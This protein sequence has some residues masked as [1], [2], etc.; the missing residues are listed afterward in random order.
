MVILGACLTLRWLLIENDLAARAGVWLVLYA[1]KAVIEVVAGIYAMFYLLVAVNYR[2]TE[3]SIRDSQ[4][5]AF[6]RDDVAVAYLCCDD[7]DVQAIETLAV[8]CRLTNLPLIVHDDSSNM[9]CRLGV[10]ELINRLRARGG[11]DIRIVRR[12]HRDGGKPAAVNHLTEILPPNAAFLL[13]CDSDSYLPPNVTALNRALEM[14][15]EPNV[16]IVQF[17]Q[18]GPHDA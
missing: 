3:E 11:V 4:P 16:A 10:D 14:F 13:L 2:A 1:I 15:S 6:E 8:L 18:Q 9:G 17:P 5:R 12:V 7:I